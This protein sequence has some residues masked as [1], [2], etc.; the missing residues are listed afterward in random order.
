MLGVCLVLFCNAVLGFLFEFCNHLA[1]EKRTGCFTLDV[2]LLSCGCYCSVPLPHGAMG[3]SVVC[4]NDISC[5]Y[6]HT[7]VM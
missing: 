7:F 2:F 1:E 6:S 5:S 3:W 4:D